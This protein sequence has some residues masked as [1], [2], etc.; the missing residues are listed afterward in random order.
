MRRP[1]SLRAPLAL[2]AAG[3]AL[4]AARWVYV[5]VGSPPARVGFRASPDELAQAEALLERFPAVDMHAHPGRTFV[6]DATNLSLPV[7]LYAMRGSFEDRAL[8]DLRA[9]RV[10]AT[11][12]NAVPDFPT[13]GVHR[14]AGLA[15][16]RPFGP[17]EAYR[18]YRT[19]IANLTAVLDRPGVE[20]VR[21][22]ADVVAAHARGRVGAVLGVE[23]ADFL[24]PDLARVV[25][26]FDDGVRV[27][28]LVH[29]YRGGPIGDVMTEAPV[30]GGLTEFGRGA[31]RAMNEVGIVVDLSHASERTAYDALDASSRPVLLSHTDLVTRSS[32]H[33]RFVSFDLARAVTESGG[34]VGAWPAGVTL[35]SLDDFA[36][37]IADLADQLGVDHVGIGTDM[38]ANYR[39][40][41]ES[42]AKMPLL[43][44]ALR[45]RGLDGEALAKILGGNFLRVMDAAMTL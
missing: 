10:A 33:P 20:L 36:G 24:A 12:L 4:A 28:T 3:L 34:V 23:G 16:A 19:Q 37:R 7:R 25:E 39:P 42:Y 41:F 9:G 8:D 2:A 5:Q 29:F 22:P 27:M 11:C 30:H 31:V 13:L 6:R 1:G 45:R 26:A 35:R 17:D 21:S 44:V 38:D 40:V 15:M 14:G 43:V 18:A 32:H